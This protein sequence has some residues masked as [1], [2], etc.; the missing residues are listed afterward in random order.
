MGP[1]V[2]EPIQ[3]RTDRDLN[4]LAFCSIQ[5]AIVQR[6]EALSLDSMT[7]RHVTLHPLAR[8]WGGGGVVEGI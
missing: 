6:R 3:K 7:G 4:D 8:G 2:S 5:A 1:M